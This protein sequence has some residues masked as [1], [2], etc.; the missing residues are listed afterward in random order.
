[1]VS[2]AEHA[3]IIWSTRTA[4]VV[5]AIVGHV[6]RQNTIR[7]VKSTIAV[8]D[9]KATKLAQSAKNFLVQSS[10]NSVTVLFGSIICQS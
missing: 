1:V 2:T 6:L 7:D 10:F 4:M 3:L 5:A 9:R 8:S